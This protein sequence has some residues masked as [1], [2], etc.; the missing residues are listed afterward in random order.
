M[1]L[2]QELYVDYELKSTYAVMLVADDNFIDCVSFLRH[3]ELVYRVHAIDY[4]SV[5]GQVWH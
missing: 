5:Y 4:Q 1:F 3:W 2:F